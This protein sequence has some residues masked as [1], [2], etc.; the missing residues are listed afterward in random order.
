MGSFGETGLIKLSDLNLT[1]FTC[2]VRLK[3][4][5]EI[6]NFDRKVAIYKR[7]A[8]H[9]RS[10]NFAIYVENEVFFFGIV[11]DLRDVITSQFDC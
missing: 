10:V 6:G 7:L 4:L 5:A 9:L 3:T 11:R 8:E 1:L 2:G